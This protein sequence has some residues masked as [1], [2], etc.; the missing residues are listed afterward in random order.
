METESEICRRYEVAF[1]AIAALDRCYYLNSCPSPVDRRNYAFRQDQL[2]ELR[3]RLYS[4]LATV[5]RAEIQ[6]FRRCRNFVRKTG[7]R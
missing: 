7:G 4:E 3:S 2:E 5:P 1:A 6:L